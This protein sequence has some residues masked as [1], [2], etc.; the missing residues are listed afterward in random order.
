MAER[1]PPN[2][3]SRVRAL[4]QQRGLSLRAL[5]ELCNLSA[6]AINLIERGKTLPSVSTLQQLASTLN[7]HITSFFEDPQGAS[8]VDP[9]SRR[10]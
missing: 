7:V 2:V 6:N 1:E 8:G 3:R 10:G 5:A 9:L 4:R